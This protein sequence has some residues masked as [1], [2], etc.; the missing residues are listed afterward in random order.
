MC[1]SANEA[2]RG[3]EEEGAHDDGREAVAT[4]ASGVDQNEAA[5]MQDFVGDKRGAGIEVSMVPKSHEIGMDRA[6][7]CWI[8]SE[9]GTEAVRPYE[10]GVGE[11]VGPGARPGFWGSGDQSESVERDEEEAG[12]LPCPYPCSAGDA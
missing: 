7:A 11:G 1:V 5:A 10:P 2:R 6:V 12:H 3:E 9:A 8:G 4:T